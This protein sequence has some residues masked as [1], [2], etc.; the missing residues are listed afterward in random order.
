M[1][2]N[3]FIGV[4]F[5][6]STMLVS[7]NAKPNTKVDPT[8][9]I[10]ETTAWMPS[11]IGL[12][13]AGLC[14]YGEDADRLIDRK[15]IYSIKTLLAKDDYVVLIDGTPVDIDRAITELIELSLKRAEKNSPPNTSALF[16]DRSNIYLSCPAHW[17]T[18]PRKR[19][20]LIAQK[21]GINIYPDQIIDEPVAAGVS[22]IMSYQQTG[23]KTL[24]G[25]TLVFDFGGGTLDVAVIKVEQPSINS[26][27]QSLSP[28][29][30]TKKLTP[31]ITVLAA[32]AI[33][34]AGD[35]LDKQIA[36][37]LL[38]KHAPITT[39]Y[40]EEET[41]QLFRR[42]AKKLKETLS[43]NEYARES[44]P[45]LADVELSKR[46][47]EEIFKPTMDQIMKLVKSVLIAAA[48][49]ENMSNLSAV[50]IRSTRELSS[51]IEQILLSG[52]MTRIPYIKQRL[53]QE[54]DTHAITDPYLGDPEKSVVAGLVHPNVVSGI[55]MHRPS[56]DFFVRY[57]DES[58][59]EIREEIIYKAF[60]PLH[61]PEDSHLNFLP[62][63]RKDLNPPEGAKSMGL[64]CRRTNGER[65]D[66]NDNKPTPQLLVKV[67]QGSINRPNHFVMYLDGRIIFQGKK[68]GKGRIHRWPVIHEGLSLKFT[69]TRE[70]SR[71]DS[72]QLPHPYWH[73]GE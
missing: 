71:A 55:N 28:E 37:H 27:L 1:S 47:V 16:L 25:K 6:T 5:G 62:S 67:G 14:L 68:A 72:W 63:Y 22:L 31:T 36:D 64:I 10:G 29:E 24:N 48:A 17:K 18:N 65:V 39:H 8:I 44:I 52:G 3:D 49:R 57:Y 60:T 46:E 30:R 58:H 21:L 61:R 35:D 41:A 33:N 4:D 40:N 34:K 15:K 2:V 51:D 59:A 66:I 23:N 13:E 20:S 45:G 11:V 54:L 43:T 38:R 32:D 42:T 53:T 69:P 73:G 50:K 26:D 19:L 7:L 56:F 70:T 9:P 12:D